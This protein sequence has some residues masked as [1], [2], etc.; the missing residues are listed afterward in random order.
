MGVSLSSGPVMLV[1]CDVTSPS[2]DD[3]TT[4]LGCDLVEPWLAGWMWEGSVDLG[5]LPDFDLP[6]SV[7]IYQ[8]PV[9]FVLKSRVE[10]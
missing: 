10:I 2:G 1:V 8:K 5:F 6:E 7:R 9:I 3:V 4:G